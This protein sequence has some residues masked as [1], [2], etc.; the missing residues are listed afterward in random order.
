[1]IKFGPWTP[2]DKY[3]EGGLNEALNVI[4]VSGG[5]RALPTE[6]VISVS[7]VSGSVLAGVSTRLVS[8][9]TKT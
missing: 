2:D 7:A 3:A 5:Y 1:M 8:G 4:P 9:L 6:S